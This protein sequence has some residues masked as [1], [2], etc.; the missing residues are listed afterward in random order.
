MIQV[1][2]VMLCGTIGVTSISGV[3]QLCQDVCAG[4]DT[5]AFLDQHPACN[6]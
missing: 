4:R 2:K 5:L 3:R 1:K 6:R